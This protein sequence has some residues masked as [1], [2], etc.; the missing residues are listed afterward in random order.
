MD[1]TCAGFSN[2]ETLWRGGG[3]GQVV[4]WNCLRTRTNTLHHAAGPKYMVKYRKSLRLR[5]SRM[6]Y[7]Y[8]IYNNGRLWGLILIQ[9]RSFKPGFPTKE[10]SPWP[11]TMWYT[12]RSSE[13]V[14]SG[15]VV[16]KNSLLFAK[17]QNGNMGEI[18]QDIDMDPEEPTREFMTNSN[19]CFYLLWMVLVVTIVHQACNGSIEIIRSSLATPVS[20]L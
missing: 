17:W 18:Q 3:G 10:C 1:S 12:D 14:S 4:S 16:T 20:E 19:W 15:L 7:E 2:A 6:F 5:P 8:V 9:I 11:F 13:D